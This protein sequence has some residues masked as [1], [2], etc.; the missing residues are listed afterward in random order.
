[1]TALYSRDPIFAQGLIA[2]QASVTAA[3]TTRSGTANA[4]Q[5]LAS[6]EEGQWL[7][8]LW[9]RPGDTIATALRVDL[10]LSPDGTAALP[11]DSVITGT[12]T[13]SATAD[14]PEYQFTKWSSDNPLYVPAGWSLWGGLSAA[15]ASGM[16]ILGQG[17][18][19]KSPANAN[20]AT[21]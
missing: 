17:Q 14:I 5:L 16:I 11:I 3:K 10:Y 21:A 9:C 15:F 13:V 2:F 1:M 4:T 12:P 19:F 7:T 18:A 8:R 6:T 20:I